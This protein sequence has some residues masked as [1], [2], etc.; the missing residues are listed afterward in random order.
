MRV[1]G[2]GDLFKHLFIPLSLFIF[3]FVGRSMA[4]TIP[5]EVKKVV[6][7]IFIEDKLAYA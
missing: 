3:F 7:F 4:E 6:T 1:E 2:G 5:D